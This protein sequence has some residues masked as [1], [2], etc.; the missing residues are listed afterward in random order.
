MRTALVAL[1]LV[2]TALAAPQPP[3]PRG[4]EPEGPSPAGPPAGGPY[5]HEVVSAWSEDGLAFTREE[6]VRLVHASVPCAVAD[7]DRVLLYFVDADRGPGRPE[8]VG[9]AE[10]RD[11]LA[12]SRLPFAIE[13]LPTRKA[14]DPCVVR[15]GPGR[16]RLYYLAS[17]GEGDPAGQEGDHAIR[18]ATSTDGVRFRDEGAVYSSPGLV[19]PDAFLFRGQW[20]LYVFGRGR[21]EIASSA[22]GRRFEYRRDLEPAGYGTTAPVPLPGGRLRLYAFEQRVP[23]GNAVRS[24]LSDDG[25][26]LTME[27]GVRIAAAKDEQLTD[28]FVIRWG[29]GHRMYLKREFRPT[30]GPGRGPAR[31]PPPGAPGPWDHDVLLWR[32][33]PEGPPV[34]VATFPR[35]GVPTLCRLSDGRIAAA[36]QWFPEGGG[37]DFDRVAIRFSS[38]EGRTFTAPVAIRVDGL[39]EGM[40]FP[41]DPTLVPLPDG[42]VRLYF[43]AHDARPSAGTAPVIGSAIGRDGL[44]YEYERGARFAVEGRPAIDCAVVLHRGRFHLIVPDS[45]PDGAGRAWHAVSEDGLSFRPLADLRLDGLRWLGNALSDDR[46]ILFLG[47]RDRPRPGRGGVFAAESPD[48]NSWREASPGPVIEG[49]DPGVV[50]LADGSLLVAVTGPPRPGTPSA[51]RRPGPPLPR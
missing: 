1:V 40:R 32:V 10:S 29:D 20:F 4:V 21:T 33:P 11:G 51:D 14:V 23:A 22:D 19:D 43:T 45:G 2:T 46:R 42:R 7:G 13:G 36:H 12:F 48:G 35:S 38:D 39:P 16:F 27:E 3:R 49:A 6:G 18:L 34:A 30:G 8:S 9:V 24:F 37:A 26:T 31:G 5:V 41:F 44:R 50:R 15:E 47:T 28:P 25:L 17:D